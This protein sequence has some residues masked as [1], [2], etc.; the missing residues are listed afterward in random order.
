MSKFV[1]YA[2]GYAWLRMASKAINVTLD[3]RHSSIWLR[4]PSSNQLGL[5]PV[6]WK[7]ACLLILILVS[8][9]NIYLRNNKTIGYSVLNET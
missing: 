9:E 1:G 2:F 7:T 5:L 8:A 6:S 3:K 4:M